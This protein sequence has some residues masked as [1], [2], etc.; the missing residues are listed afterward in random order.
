MD[1]ASGGGGGEVLRGS[2]E[3]AG[4][5]KRSSSRSGLGKVSLGNKG[6]DSRFHG[7]MIKK[8]QFFPLPPPKPVPP[9]GSSCQGGP[10]VTWSPGYSPVSSR[11]PPFPPSWPVHSGSAHSLPLKVSA[12]SP[13]AP[14]FH[15]CPPPTHLHT[16]AKGSF[17]KPKLDCSPSLFLPFQS[18]HKTSGHSLSFL[19]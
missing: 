14:S 19:Q 9:P 2:W 7:D 10:I 3:E 15:S 6:R 16:V 1:F 17:I 13:W 11:L 8:G 4:G 18:L 5:R 12:W